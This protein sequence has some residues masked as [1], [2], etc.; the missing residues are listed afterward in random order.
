MSSGQLDGSGPRSNICVLLVASGAA[1]ESAALSAVSARPGMVVIRRC[2]D[3][4][5]LLAHAATGQAHVA[6][7]SLDAPGLDNSA[8]DRLRADG[9]EVVVVAADPGSDLVRDRVGRIGVGFT[10]AE[11]Q[12]A[13]VPEAVLA[14]GSSRPDEDV[15]TRSGP[16]IGP[17]RGWGCAVWGPLGAPGRTTV[18]LGIAGE[19]ARR[20]TDPLVLDVDPWASSVSQHLGVLDEVSG[21]LACGRAM[22]TGDLPSRYVGLQRRVAGLRVVT[23]LP[24]PDRWTEIRSGTVESLVDLGRR[25]GDVVV[26][27]G[28]SLEEDLGA[29]QMGR[30][31]RNTM[32]LEALGTVDALV[33]VGSADPVGLARLARGLVELRE[34]TEP[35]PLH[36]VVNRMR[37]SVGWSE[38]EVATMVAGF[39]DLA[40]IHFLPDDRSATDRALLAGRTLAELGDSPLSRAMSSLVDG[41]RPETASARRGLRRRRAASARRS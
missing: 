33:V 13:Q 26:D 3:V 14:A 35:R 41:L 38:H 30:A 27:T 16:A 4:T 19:L 39:G 25:Q 18:T 1:W 32:T 7:V 6:V 2:V 10:V 23:G 40:G 37:G 28:F 24:R 5:D 21:L 12:V 9:V 34:V 36:V 11:A 20:G 17:G 8:V 22:A 31:G 15:P 29:E